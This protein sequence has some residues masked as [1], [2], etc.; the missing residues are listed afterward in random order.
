MVDRVKCQRLV[1]QISDQLEPKGFNVM[2]PFGL[3][4]YN[5]IVTPDLQM[6]GS[7]ENGDDN[8]NNNALVIMIGNTNELWDPF[9]KFY[10][11]KNDTTLPLNPLNYYV[12]DCIENLNLIEVPNQVYWDHEREP[13]KLVDIQKMIRCSQLGTFCPISYLCIHTIYGPW[14]AIRSVLVFNHV[15]PPPL[16]HPV[17]SKS[18][19]AYITTISTNKDIIQK[20]VQEAIHD[21]NIE[22]SWKKWLNVRYLLSPNHPWTFSLE[23]IDFHYHYFDVE[24]LHEILCRSSSYS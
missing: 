1:Q 7:D 6:K 21:T 9:I 22:T 16:I 8:N 19:S 5:K 4:L 13:G 18:P 14:F 2:H 20:A 10:N 15:E 3:D 24:Y 12:K 23:Q 17:L 11:N